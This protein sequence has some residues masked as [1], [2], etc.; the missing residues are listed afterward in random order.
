MQSLEKKIFFLNYYFWTTSEP[1]EILLYTSNFKKLNRGL[2][3][4]LTRYFNKIKVENKPDK[5]Q[6]SR[7]LSRSEF[8]W[9]IPFKDKFN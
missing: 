7:E 9:Y 1:S 8:Y 3:L 4:F 5:Q 6:T 2:D